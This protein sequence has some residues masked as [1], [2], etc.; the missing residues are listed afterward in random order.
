MS[1]KQNKLN[2]KKKKGKLDKNYVVITIR[3]V[4]II[5]YIYFGFNC[6]I[7]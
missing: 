1:K 4:T 6:F 2:K 5:L 3:K 7:E